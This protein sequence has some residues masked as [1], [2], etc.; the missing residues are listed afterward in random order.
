MDARPLSNTEV[1]APRVIGALHE[2][3]RYLLA[4]AAALALDA[5]VYMALIRLGGIHYLAAAPIGYVLGILVIYLLSTRWV[6]SNRRLT[7]VRSE[8]FVFTLIGIVGLLLNQVVI[9]L[10]VDGLSMSYELAKLT[11]ASLVFCFNFAGRKLIL[12]TRF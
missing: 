1:R 6:F 4:S 10:C 5:S 9:Y 11:S 2:G 8:F 3:S 7:N 12:F